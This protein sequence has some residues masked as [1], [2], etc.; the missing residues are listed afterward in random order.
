[1]I[2]N[3][4]IYLETTENANLKNTIINKICIPFLKHTQGI[5]FPIEKKGQVE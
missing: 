2:T 1:M 3:F 5:S 4:Q